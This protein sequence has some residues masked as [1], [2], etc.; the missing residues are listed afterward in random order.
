MGFA[1][2][3]RSNKISGQIGE[4]YL[5]IRKKQAYATKTLH[6]IDVRRIDRAHQGH[7]S[8]PFTSPEEQKAQS[9]HQRETHC[10][11]IKAKYSKSPIIIYSNNNTKCIQVSTLQ[12]VIASTSDVAVGGYYMVAYKFRSLV[13]EFG[14]FSSE[15]RQ[16]LFSLFV[17]FVFVFLLYGDYYCSC[18]CY[19]ACFLLCLQRGYSSH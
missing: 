1:T 2:G 17:I 15:F 14:S 16:S 18:A 11:C 10:H 6:C 9:D 8:Y 13:H 19:A 4:F 7:I 5:I 12:S 3:R